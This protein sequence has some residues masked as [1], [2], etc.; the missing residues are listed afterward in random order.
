MGSSG[1]DLLILDLD[2][3]GEWVVSTTPRP[4][5][6]GKARYQLY[7]RLGGGLDVGEKSRPH[8][9]LIPGPSSSEPVAI[10]TEIPGPPI[11]DYERTIGKITEHSCRVIS[12]AF[13]PLNCGH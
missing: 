7:K 2:A 5:Y 1:I 8:R 4:L 9:D 3:R 13:L 12:Q 11:Y 6:P 10:P